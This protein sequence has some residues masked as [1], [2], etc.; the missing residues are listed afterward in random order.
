MSEGDNND[1][2][3][4]GLLFYELFF[5]CN[6]E[7]L[8]EDG[9]RD[10]LEPY[11][12]TPK[13]A[14]SNYDYFFHHACDNEKVT[15]GIIRYLL[16]YFPDAASATFEGWAPLHN[17]CGN[18]NVT[19]GIIQVLINSAPDSVRSVSNTG[20]TPLHML[21]NNIKVDEATAM[22]ILKLL[23]EKYPEAV[24]HTNNNDGYL[25]IHIASVRTKSP[26]FCQV[27]IEAYP[28]SERM[29]EAEGKLPLHFACANNTVAT[30]KYL[31]K[32]YPDAINHAKNSGHY[33]IHA[34]I[35]GTTSRDNPAASVEIVQFLL[36]CDPNVKFQGRS[37][38]RYACQMEYNDSNID[39]ALEVIKLLFDA[40][41]EAIE[42]NR[43]TRHLHRRHQQVQAFI[44]NVLVYSRQAKDQRLMTTRDSNG[45]LPLHRALHDNVRL[46]SIK[47]LVKGNPSAL[48]SPD[49]S[50]SLPL[51][52]ACQYQDSAAVIRYLVELDTTSLCAVDQ[53]INT[54]L[55][56]SCRGA[57]H[58]IIALLLESYDAVSVSKRNV[59]KK[60]PID[61]LWESNAVEDRENVEYMESVF[62]LLKAYPETLRNVGAEGQ[63]AFVACSGQS[64]N[65]KKRKY[66]HEL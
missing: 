15:E 5:F 10:I 22:Q 38:L 34:A 3:T 7:V 16:E 8:T 65:G 9:L 31:Y 47:L 55:H 28:G 63:F 44:N 58:E 35:M 46:G 33:P 61:L 45:Q 66:G 48:Q 18:P 39:A 21:C 11:R 60:L 25:P 57:R 24:R 1:G 41:P 29:T 20:N 2:Q 59:Q 49:N 64:G 36:D 30:V 14:L 42:D 23:I 51:H 4:A 50:G 43:I 27:L 12:L 40:H 17:A 19:T 62:R 37:L 53:E 56:H 13:D 6:T 54:V 26:E 52:I 32:L